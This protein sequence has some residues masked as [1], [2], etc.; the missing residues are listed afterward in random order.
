M[1]KISIY[2]NWSYVFLKYFGNQNKLLAKWEHYF[3]KNNTN[4]KKI[5][6]NAH[7]ILEHTSE[8]VKT[9][10]SSG[11]CSR[12]MG[13]SLLYQIIKIFESGLTNLAF[14]K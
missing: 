11:Q 6:P 13:S 2:S 9:Q 10:W 3:K 8:T 7:W 4:T 5:N 12:M 14:Y 1:F